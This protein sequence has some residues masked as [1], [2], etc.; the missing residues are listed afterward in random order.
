M[1]CV[2]AG[3]PPQ[4][5]SLW[6]SMGTSS[7]SLLG[8]MGFRT[9]CFCGLLGFCTFI[10]PTNERHLCVAEMLPVGWGG[11]SPWQRCCNSGN[12][13][14]SF[15][16][17]IFIHIPDNKQER[18]KERKGLNVWMKRARRRGGLNPSRSGGQTTRRYGNM[19]SL[20][21]CSRLWEGR[22]EGFF[23]SRS[24]RSLVDFRWKDTSRIF[25]NFTQESR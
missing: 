19:S 23:S 20:P 12:M 8:L 2:Q 21:P 16:C 9:W 13:V 5:S 22:Q 7:A 17:W 15:S 14:A 6:V 1:L 24:P 11:P 10:T 4:V 25:F 18:E 3:V